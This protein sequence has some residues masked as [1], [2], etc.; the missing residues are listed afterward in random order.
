MVRP[1]SRARDR[2]TLAMVERAI[3]F[4][5]GGHTAG[6]RTLIQELAGLSDAALMLRL[7]RLP[8]PSS[9][10]GLLGARLSGLIII[11]DG[12][13]PFPRRRDTFGAHDPL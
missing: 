9:G 4:A 8:A 12:E 2:D 7:C 11:R 1:A 3:R 5:G 10:S 6:E 13:L